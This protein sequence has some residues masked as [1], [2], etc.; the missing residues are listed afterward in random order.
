MQAAEIAL[1]LLGG[2]VAGVVN[3]L[4]GG[5]SL[6]TVPLLL[7]LGL[8]GTEANGTNRIG[9]LLQSAVAAWRFRA[10]GVSMLRE[11]ARWSAPMLIGAGLGAL[12]V[13]R[14]P[15]ATF[16]R[17][18]AWLMLLLAVPTA[19]PRRARPAAAPRASGRGSALLLFAIG[20]YGGAF[21]AGVGIP[22]LAALSRA[23]FDL[24][25]ANA[26]KVV[27][28]TALTA[29]SVPFFVVA[30]QV[31]WGPALV[32]GAGFSA[33]AA[34]GARVAVRGGE[35]PIRAVLGIAV[36]ALALKLLLG[37]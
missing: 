35:G 13:S 32:L 23:G 16:E 15:D 29:T 9:T 17:S 31:R 22:L 12:W 14:I 34:L 27:A 18:F 1:L 2:T 19:W 26:V 4:A 11:G 25:R 7:L 8:P 6:L 24:V 21:Q 37:S 5:G 36:V 10:E 30:G 28:T 33:G 3:T 20:G